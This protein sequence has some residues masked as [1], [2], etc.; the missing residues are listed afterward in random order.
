VA[1][2]APD[3]SGCTAAIVSQANTAAIPSG[4]AVIRLINI[5]MADPVA[6][7]CET[8]SHIQWKFE[9]C[10]CQIAE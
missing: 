4:Q 8:L 6:C 3:L 2:V 1:Q 5:S 10:C 7:L 9:N